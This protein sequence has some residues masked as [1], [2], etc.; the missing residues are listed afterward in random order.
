MRD[1]MGQKF[2]E[3]L[4]A[5]TIDSNPL[6]TEDKEM[7]VSLGLA[8]EASMNAK[9]PTDIRAYQDKAR[10]LIFNMKDPKNPQLCESLLKGIISPPDFVSSD[11][12]DLASREKI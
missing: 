12:K 4:Q 2:I 1:A 6:T 3:I 8:I 9:F 5:A 7:A 10:S 11:P